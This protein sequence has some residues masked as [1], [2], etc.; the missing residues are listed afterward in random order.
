VY[1][2]ILFDAD[3]TLLDFDKAQY[4]GFRVVLERY[5]IVY[6]DKVY[7]EYERINHSLWS[8]FERG[9]IGT[10]YVQTERFSALFRTL[11]QNFNGTDA[12]GVYQEAL[13]EQCQLMPYALEVCRELS[14]FTTL[15]IVTNGVGMTQKARIAK[16]EIANYISLVVV[17]EDVGFQKPSINFFNEVFSRLN[18]PNLSDILIVGDS[19]ASDIQGGINAGIRTCY[20]V[21]ESEGV[22]TDITPDY[23]INDLRKLVKIANYNM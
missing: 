17:S 8:A 15:V 6:T 19:L 20:Y 5:G 12:N 4:S 21:P 2:I 13:K 1:K 3:N 9:E 22:I 7:E 18:N 10:D 14:T 23:V 11:G 16:S